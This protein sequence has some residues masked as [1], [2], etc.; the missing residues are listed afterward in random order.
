MVV[1]ALAR[2]GDSSPS[3]CSRAL[4]VTVSADAHPRDHRAGH[5]LTP[6]RIA[7]GLHRGRRI[8]LHIERDALLSEL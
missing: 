6:N 8:E 4:E 2:F 1:R 7:S 5:S 3:S